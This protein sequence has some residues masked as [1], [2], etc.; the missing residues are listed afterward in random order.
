MNTYD[1]KNF[2]SINQGALD[3]HD[4]KQQEKLETLTKE[5]EDLLTRIK[6]SLEGKV[7]DVIL[8]SR[9]K[10]H[11]VCIVSGD[12][13]SFETEKV[14]NQSPDEKQHVRAD[15]ILEI[16]PDHPILEA[17]SLTKDENTLNDYSQLLYD[18]ALLIEGLPIENPSEFSLKIAEL[19]VKAS[20]K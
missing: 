3:L 8:S 13:I 9:L 2:K 12:G 16:N 15:R 17:L 5:N 11:P 6:K 1:E 7:D 19:M 4:D 10:S 18:Q 14:V 20:H